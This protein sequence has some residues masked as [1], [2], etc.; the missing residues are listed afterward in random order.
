M[1]WTHALI[2]TAASLPGIA[3]ALPP[4][5]DNLSR[6]VRSTPRAAGKPLPPRHVLIAVGMAQS[7]LL[8]AVAAL[9][10]AA[11]GPSVGLGRIVTNALTT[12]GGA[13]EAFTF[14]VAG[15]AVMLGA[16]Y[17]VFRPRLDAHTRTVSE[18]MRRD[19]G[20]ASRVLYGG[21]V[22]EVLVRWGV[23]SV[24]FWLLSHAFGTG[25]GAFWTANVVAGVLFAVGHWPA[26]LAAG[27]RRT[28]AFFTTSLV[29]NAFLA[30]LYGW[31]LWRYGLVGAVLGHAVTHLLWYPLDR[32]VWRREGAPVTAA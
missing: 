14:A 18:N 23:L 4:L 7:T 26:Y 1:N 11:S 29:L 28:P 5:I 8:A 10:G 21:V 19:M 12:P 2:V 17:G 32:A 22:E 16:Y 13:L 27:C 24:L 3:V 30:V 20:L 6:R 15:S 25:A 31:M 9:A